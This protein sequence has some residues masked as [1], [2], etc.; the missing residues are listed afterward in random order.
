M[1]LSVHIFNSSV[2]FL[3]IHT[4]QM[5]KHTS[6]YIV[7]QISWQWQSK[8]AQKYLLMKHCLWMQSCQKFEMISHCAFFSWCALQTTIS[9]S[10][11]CVFLAHSLLIGSHVSKL[12][13]V[14]NFQ[15]NYQ[16]WCGI[17]TLVYCS[18]SQFCLEEEASGQ[19]RPYFSLW[20][21]YRSLQNR[22]GHWSEQQEYFA[23]IS[24]W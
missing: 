6:N 16:L 23:P 18:T 10:F 9:R 2:I 4:M 11:Q 20:L 15:L 17:Q 24:L 7:Q 1:F 13:H 12:K 14:I 19:R 8:S 21:L 5:K 3:R 22:V